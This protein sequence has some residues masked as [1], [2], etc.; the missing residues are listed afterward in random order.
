MFQ[1][2]LLIASVSLSA[3]AD[4]GGRAMLLTEGDGKL[5]NLNDRE[6]SVKLFKKGTAYYADLAEVGSALRM[7][8]NCAKGEH[9]SNPNPVT[10][11]TCQEQKPTN[12]NSVTTIYFEKSGEPV[13]SVVAVVGDVDTQGKFNQYG[14]LAGFNL[15]GLKNE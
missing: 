3:Y 5:Y 12:P 9:F 13:V 14:F 7:R 6:F 11:F 4:L 8:L 15:A 1:L 2:T 10:L